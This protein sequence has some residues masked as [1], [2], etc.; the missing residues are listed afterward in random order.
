MVSED[1][2]AE[3]WEGVSP[4]LHE[5]LGVS[6]GG[7]VDDLPDEINN[8][9]DGWDDE[10][11]HRFA[12]RDADKSINKGEGNEQKVEANV[13]DVDDP[14]KDVDSSESSVVV[15]VGLGSSGFGGSHGPDDG[16]WNVGGEVENGLTVSDNNGNI[17]HNSKLVDP[18]GPESE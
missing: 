14:A 18:W 16:T 9:T 2:V 3:F 5:G 4:A 17:S 15:S 10:G 13:K 1:A 8:E 12:G 6:V 11:W 7:G